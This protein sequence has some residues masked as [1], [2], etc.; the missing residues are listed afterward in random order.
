MAKT[1]P[2]YTVIATMPVILEMVRHEGSALLLSQSFACPHWVSRSGDADLIASY[3]KH[4][5]VIAG[6]PNMA[7]WASFGVESVRVLT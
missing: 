6:R 2:Q 3:T 4:T 5:A 1:Q 7:R